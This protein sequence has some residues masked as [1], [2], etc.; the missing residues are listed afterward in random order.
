MAKIDGHQGNVIN[1]NTSTL[2]VENAS[3]Q[4][5]AVEPVRFLHLHELLK[6]LIPS[7]FD[8]QMRH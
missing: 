4:E 7:G 6:W 3:Q 8:Q 5:S 1:K 2:L